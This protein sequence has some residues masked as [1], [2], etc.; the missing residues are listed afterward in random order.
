[1]AL[2]S[3]TKL[4]ISLAALVIAHRIYWET[5]AGARHRALK[6]QH[7]CLPAKQ[8]SHNPFFFGLKIISANLKAL[9]NHKLLDLWSELLAS[10]NAHTIQ[11]GVLGQTIIYTD[12]PENIKA[13]LSTQ[14]ESWSLGKE[15]IDSMTRYLGKGIFTTEG[16]AWKHSREMLRPCFERSQ[17]AD[18]SI[19]EKHTKRLI[20]LIPKDGTTINLQPLFHQL[21]LDVATEFL[22]GRSTEA[23][24]K[25][26]EDKECE[27]F[28]EAFEYCQIPF[29][30][31]NNAK[32]GVLG[33]FLPDLKFKKKA[34]II[35]GT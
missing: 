23:L 10:N 9:K 35:R 31:E 32:F 17:V 20:E 8:R 25:S 21:T 34:K 33:L 27:Q 28:I 14:F 6:K 30:G 18:V 2:F 3:F 15:R 4:A 13:I 29:G 1:M 19:M 22:F 12:D 26:R 16:A 11:Q 5:T 7:G 24:D